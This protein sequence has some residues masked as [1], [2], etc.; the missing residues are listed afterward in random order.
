MILF[1]FPNMVDYVLKTE[2]V[3]KIYRYI[4][5]NGEHEL[6]TLQLNVIERQSADT[7]LLGSTFFIF[8]EKFD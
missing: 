4:S 2:K 7:E 1:N 3:K 5:E 8:H 6:T